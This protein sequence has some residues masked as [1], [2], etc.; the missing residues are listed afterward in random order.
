MGERL[1]L[2]CNVDESAPK[3]YS[4][5]KKLFKIENRLLSTTTPCKRSKKKTPKTFIKLNYDRPSS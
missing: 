1:K 4:N 5:N 3:N 2:I